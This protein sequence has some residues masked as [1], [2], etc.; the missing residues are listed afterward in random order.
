MLAEGAVPDVML[1]E[2]DR[3][4]VALKRGGALQTKDWS[5]FIMTM[6]R[7]IFMAKQDARGRVFHSSYTG[8]NRVAMAGT[9]GIFRGRITGIR[10]DSG[11]YAPGLHSLIAF[12]WALKMYRVNLKGISLLDPG[13]A[14][15]HDNAEQFLVHKK[16]EEQKEFN[17]GAQKEEQKLKDTQDARQNWQMNKTAAQS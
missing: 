15:I 2:S 9:I 4:Y 16:N 17:E 7:E 12:L 11:H 8:G 14:L 13:G 1:A 3:G 6:S 10:T 5:G